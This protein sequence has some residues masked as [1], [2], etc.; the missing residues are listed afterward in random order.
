MIGALGDAGLLSRLI[1]ENAVTRRQTETLAQQASTE[2]VSETYGGLGAAAHISLSLHPQVAASERW[3]ANIDA[4]QGRIGA[5]QSALQSVSAIAADFYA[6][7]SSL[8]GLDAATTVEYVASSARDALKQV[9]GLLNTQVGDV[10]VFAGQ[11]TA[12]PPVPDPNGILTSGFFANTQT[13]V[14]GLAANGAAAT[15]AATLSIAGGTSPFSATLGG[16][17][18]IAVGEGER[19]G[20]G[21]LADRNTLA[22]SAGASTTGSYMRDVMRALATLGSLSS[23]QVSAPG[24]AGLVADTR[25]GLRGAISAMSSEAGSLGDVERSLATR[26]TGLG[27]QALA[28]RGQL[29]SIE[30]VDLAKTLTQLTQRRTQLEASYQIIAGLKDLSLT[31]YL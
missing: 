20:V 19:V 27:D 14:A 8:G 22:T 25:N 6:R 26:R 29:S 30:N 10:H 31:N 5:T 15:A 1:Q 4:V 23:G 7:T 24:F 21:L 12:N 18:P 17:P 16:V 2:R 13:A 9:A 11:D 28:L 3:Q